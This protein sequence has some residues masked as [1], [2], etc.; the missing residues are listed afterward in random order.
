[1]ISA[2]D[3]NA[4][5]SMTGAIEEYVR[6][7]PELWRL[8]LKGWASNMEM[9][10]KLM[11]KVEQLAEMPQWCDVS[12]LHE[13]AT[14]KSAPFIQICLQLC[15]RGISHSPVSLLKWWTRM[16]ACGQT[17]I[18]TYF[19]WLTFKPSGCVTGQ[20]ILY[21]CSRTQQMFDA[22]LVTLEQPS[23]VDFHLRELLGGLGSKA[24]IHEAWKKFAKENHPDKGGD[25]ERFL[26]VK[27]CYDEWCK[28]CQGG[29]K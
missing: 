17:N 1:M 15:K 19:T 21:N 3:L 18:I 10:A 27:V 28:L 14:E 6:K 5:D 25:P 26:E 12:W 8:Y 24:D 16:I 22:I 11:E 13:L 20:D 4:L 2:D 9:R 29:K 23:S 7:K